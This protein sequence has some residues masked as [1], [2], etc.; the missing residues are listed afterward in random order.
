E[1][2]EGLWIFRLMERESPAAVPL[3]RVE[4]NLRNRMIEER[5]EARLNAL[6]K[7][8]AG[9]LKITVDEQALERV[10]PPDRTQPDPR[11]PQTPPSLP[12]G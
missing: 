7:S 3:E 5:I 6:Y 12:S 2:D 9:S 8:T 4:L 10:P 1:T 11:I